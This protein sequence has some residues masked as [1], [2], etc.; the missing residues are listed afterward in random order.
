VKEQI[1]AVRTDRELECPR[2]DAGL[3][4]RSVEL[5]T[6]P[7]GIAESELVAATADA[8][9]LLMCYTP[10]TARVIE[11]APR[12][13]GIVKYGVGID[14]I[15]IDAA[16]RRGIP[17]VNI[18]EYA[19][20]TVAEGAFA[21]MIALA[22][23]L[24]AMHQQM[25]A[26]GWAWPVERWLGNDLAGKTVGLVGVGKIGRSFARMAGAGFRMRVLGFDPFVDAETMRRAGVEKCESLAEMLPQA[27]FVSL[28]SILKPETR[29][30]I[31]RAELASMKPSAIL[32]NVS[33]GALV[34]EAAL[35]EALASGQIA[36][37]GLD[38]YSQ[39]PLALEGHPLSALFKMPNVIL[40]P[41]LTFYTQE[42]MDR[43]EVETLE[44][45]DEILAGRPVTIKSRDP[46]LRA[47]TKGVNFVS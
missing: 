39:E 4:E 9:L 42:A 28:H 20:E 3:R 36:G 25:Q 24:G 34:D 41:H 1:K 46:R 14:A 18:P 35:V 26:A 30:I 5:V 17:V 31:G 40:M 37:A 15:D 7:E 21:L 13:K 12:L 11:N 8:D 45:C 6:L 10:I 43:L 38:V 33:R 16:R 27:D 29:H 19:E 32:I 47:Q 22:R 2:V 23:K 44:R